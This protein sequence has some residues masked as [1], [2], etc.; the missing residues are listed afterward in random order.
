METNYAVD[1][2]QHLISAGIVISDEEM[3]ESLNSM[4]EP[5][6]SYTQIL[7]QSDQDALKVA[8][9]AEV[10]M[11]LFEKRTFQESIRRHS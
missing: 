6:R 1:P 10:A 8:G 4:S 5:R 11:F 7:L 2:L 3:T 9:L